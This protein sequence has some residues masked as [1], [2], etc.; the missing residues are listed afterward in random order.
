MMAGLM[1]LLS[2]QRCIIQYGYSGSTRVGV[3]TLQML[4]FS[5]QLLPS[6]IYFMSL[7]IMKVGDNN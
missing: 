7:L 5:C 3:L 2:V 6:A 4:A 1:L